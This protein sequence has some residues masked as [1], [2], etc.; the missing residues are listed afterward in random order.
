MAHTRTQ[1]INIYQ[2]KLSHILKNSERA[3]YQNALNSCRNNLNKSWTIIKEIINK[4]KNKSNKLPKITINGHLCDDPQTIANHFNTFFT[5][6]G[7]ILDTKIPKNST[8]PLSFI[9]KNYT[10]NIFLDPTSELEINKIVDN[11]KD[12][13]VGWDNFP[14]YILKEHKLLNQDLTTHY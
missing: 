12:C 10:F 5:N 8:N 9:P 7:S 3:H 2:N 14:S 11:L 4:K 13:A 6:I 1:K